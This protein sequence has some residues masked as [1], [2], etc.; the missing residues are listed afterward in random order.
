VIDTIFFDFD[1]VI[2][3][4]VNVKTEAFRQMYSKYGQH[5]CQKVVE[6]H[7]NNGGISR[8]EKIQHYHKVFLQ[9]VLRKDE[10]IELSNIFSLLVV[11]RVI[12]SKPIP[13]AIE[14]I[15]NDLKYK[16]FI[17]SATPESEIIHIVDA[18]GLK[19]Y[20]I[21]IYGSPVGKGE[22]VKRCIRSFNLNNE[23]CIFIGDALAD[24]EA[25]VMNNI[26]FLLIENS[27]NAQIFGNNNRT[28]RAQNLRNIEKLILKIGGLYS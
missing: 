10:L 27:M 15:E 5:V 2:L 13:G 8:F 26:K 25:S 17:I 28:S 4:S 9:K 6:H 16:K 21:G 1:G 11:E 14:F 23:K 12:K 3:D 20:F 18:L 19:K 7:L 22:H 24:Y